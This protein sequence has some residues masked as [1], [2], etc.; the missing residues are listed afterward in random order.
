MPLVWPRRKQDSATLCGNSATRPRYLTTKKT[1]YVES[2]IGGDIWL[3]ISN[4]KFLFN[5]KLLTMTLAMLLC[6]LYFHIPKHLWREF[7]YIMS[8][9]RIWLPHFRRSIICGGLA[10]FVSHYQRWPLFVFDNQQ[11]KQQLRC[12]TIA[13]DRLFCCSQAGLYRRHASGISNRIL[14]DGHSS[15]TQRPKLNVR[16]CLFHI[17]IRMRICENILHRCV[18]DWTDAGIFLNSPHSGFIFHL[19]TTLSKYLLKKYL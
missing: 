17:S 12:D 14:S 15:Q 8:W 5:E 9:W 13:D 3:A 2:R 19:K 4:T 11:G 10:L 6:S 16:R 18:F 1:V 7:L